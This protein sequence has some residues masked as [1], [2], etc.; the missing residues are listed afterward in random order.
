MENPKIALLLA[1]ACLLTATATA[2]AA[3]AGETSWIQTFCRGNKST[4]KL[5]FYV[6]DV[7]AGPNATLFN[8]ANSSITAT[9]PTAFGRVNVFDDSVTVAP[10][11]TSEEVARAQGTTTSMDLNVQA[12]SMNLNFFLTSGEFN[13]STVTVIGR[14]QFADE[15]RE[16]SVA[17]GSKAFRDARGYAITKTVSFEEATNYSVLEYTIYVKTSKRCSY[18][19]S[20]SS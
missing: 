2:T 9:S 5:H 14:N 17:T 16:L 12:Y 15:E 10:D 11:I 13:G 3:G 19:A 20:A 1:I 8:V 4:T 18:V 7:R 6:H